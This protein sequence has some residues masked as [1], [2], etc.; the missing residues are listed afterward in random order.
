LNFLETL[1]T[2]VWQTDKRTL[3][4]LSKDAS[5]LAQY[6]ESIELYID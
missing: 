6:V 1:A 5:G 3:V 2:E 4:Q